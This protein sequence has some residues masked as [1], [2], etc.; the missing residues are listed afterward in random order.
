MFK[1][2]QADTQDPGLVGWFILERKIPRLPGEDRG[3]TLEPTL[4]LV[5]ATQAW[6]ATLT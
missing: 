1:A 4:P 3:R 6:Q 5:T 2:S